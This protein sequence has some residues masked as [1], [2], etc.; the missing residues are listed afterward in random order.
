MSSICGWCN[1]NNNNN[2]EHSGNILY[3]VQHHHLVPIHH[4][5]IIPHLHKVCHQWG[6]Y[7]LLLIKTLIISAVCVSTSLW[8]C[9]DDGED[10]VGLSLTSHSWQHS[11]AYLIARLA[12]HIVCQHRVRS[13]LPTSSPTT[14]ILRINF[15]G[16]ISAKVVRASFPLFAPSQWEDA[17]RGRAVFN[18]TTLSVILIFGCCFLFLLL[19]FVLS[20]RF[21]LSDLIDVSLW[22]CLRPHESARRVMSFPCAHCVDMIVVVFVGGVSSLPGT[23]HWVLPSIITIILILIALCLSFQHHHYYY[24]LSIPR[25]GCLPSI[26]IMYQVRFDQYSLQFSKWEQ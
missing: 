8:Q 18:R 6:W 4:V 17:V 26:N 24:Q 10:A 5:C 23:L 15:P 1:Y 7:D 22:H 21:V 25:P 11:Q 13:I 19:L 14:F 12:F 16:S 20:Y 2:K 3:P 9:H